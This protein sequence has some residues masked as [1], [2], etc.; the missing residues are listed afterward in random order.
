MGPFFCT[1][2]RKQMMLKKMNL[3]KGLVSVRFFASKDPLRPVESHMHEV[4]S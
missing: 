2:N 4:T 3:M 1:K